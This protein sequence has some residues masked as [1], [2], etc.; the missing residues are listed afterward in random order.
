MLGGLPRVQAGL[1]RLAHT[2][3]VVG[4][5]LAA[6]GGLGWSLGHPLHLLPSLLGGW[7]VNSDF[8]HHG[9]LGWAR[10]GLQAP[11]ALVPHPSPSRALGPRRGLRPAPRSTFWLAN[12]WEIIREAPRSPLPTVPLPPS[13]RPVLGRTWALRSC[14]AALHAVFHSLTPLVGA[15][16]CKQPW[17]T[18]D[19]T[20]PAAGAARAPLPPAPISRMFEF[21]PP[22]RRSR[23]HRTLVP[24]PHSP[25]IS[26]PNAPQPLCFRSADTMKLI[27]TSPPPPADGGGRR[28]ATEAAAELE[29]E[30]LSTPCKRHKRSPQPTDSLGAAP[31][32]GEL[33]GG[34]PEV[35]CRAGGAKAQ[36]DEP[37][38]PSG[39]AA[40]GGAGGAAM[41]PPPPRAP[42]ARRP[43]LA[44]ASAPSP[45]GGVATPAAAEV[46]APPAQLPLPGAPDC[47]LMPKLPV[48]RK[49]FA[50]AA[51]AGGGA[52]GAAGAA[53]AVAQPTADQQAATQ[54]FLAAMEDQV[55]APAA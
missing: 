35:S 48:Q 15:G 17:K 13:S 18:P 10:K 5:R 40:A 52:A 55:R 2:R 9:R 32:A 53:A 27:R 34:S 1:A 21:P 39:A 54:A 8:T 12:G 24:L 22:S 25:L 14:P 49:L 6:I 41:P 45:G 33:A 42:H 36:Q 29:D 51:A 31:A 46:P 23:A 3:C 30:M 43:G 26:R 44:Y 28:L 7:S 20:L 4:W 37:G 11:F 19:P 47:Y 16:G 38:T 50:A